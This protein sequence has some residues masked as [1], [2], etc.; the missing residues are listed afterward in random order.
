MPETYDF[1][2]KAL[3]LANVTTLLSLP[4]G[5]D[6][7]TEV[8]GSV[9]EMWRGSAHGTPTFTYSTNCDTVVMNVDIKI[10]KCS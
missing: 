1:Q 9:R 5:L 2:P 8:E 10:L 4:A 6:D 3:V 7:R